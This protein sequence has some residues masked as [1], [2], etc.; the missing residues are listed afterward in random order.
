M[1]RDVSLVTVGDVREL[2]AAQQDSLDEGLGREPA[3]PAAPG[4]PELDLIYT[5]VRKI[6]ERD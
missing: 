2:G 1:V 5:Y 3:A 4:S 6:G